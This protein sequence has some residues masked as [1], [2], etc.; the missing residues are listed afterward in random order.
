MVGK[1][2]AIPQKTSPANKPSAAIMDVSGWIGNWLRFEKSQISHR[3]DFEAAMIDYR[4][5]APLLPD[6]N[7][8]SKSRV[9]TPTFLIEHNWSSAFRGA[10]EF[11]EGDYRLP[12]EN[13]CFEFKISGRHVCAFALEVAGIKTIAIAVETKNFGWVIP[14]FTLQLTNG[15]WK[16]ER[17]V[18]S[19]WDQQCALLAQMVANQVRAVCISLEA[20][21]TVPYEVAPPEKLNKARE[22]RGQIPFLSYHVVRLNRKQ[23]VRTEG[24][25][26]I[27]TKTRLHF[28]RG[29]YRHFDAA[30]PE[31]RAWVR[32]HLVGNPDLGFVDKQY[33][34]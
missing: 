7:V 8:G 13:T 28:R 23:I 33:R 1:M 15:Q 12:F 16:L 21:A 27:G 11:D 22:R 25:E 29:H 34:L 31:V 5:L 17:T 6:P 3:H 24:G 14:H 32:W 26:M 18:Q 19:T 30:R 20:E 2:T 9:P 10:Q 4:V